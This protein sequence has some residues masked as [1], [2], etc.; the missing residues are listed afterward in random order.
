MKQVLRFLPGILFSA[1]LLF[2]VG[3]FYVFLPSLDDGEAFTIRWA[4]ITIALFFIIE[5]GLVVIHLFRSG[6]EEK[7]LKASPKLVSVIIACY[8][9]EQILEKTLRQVFTHKIPKK[10]IFVV[11]DNSSDGTD[12]IAKQMGVRLIRNRRNLQKGLS[13]SKVIKQVKTPFTLILDD[14]T[15]IAGITIPTNLIADGFS[16]VAFNVLPE[17]KG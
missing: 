15:R 4:I 10:N 13:I 6:T 16:A 9:G 3:F 11:S 14:D 8:N 2:L 12:K 7:D 5:K 17:Q 1:I